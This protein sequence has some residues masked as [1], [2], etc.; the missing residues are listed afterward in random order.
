[1]TDNNS[2]PLPSL[3][4]D[5][6]T[7]KDAPRLIW[8]KVSD[9]VSLLWPDNPKLHDIGA[10]VQ[11]IS[12]HGFQELPKYDHHLGIKAGNGRVEALDW[13]QK[14]GGYDLPRGLASLPDSG[15]WAMPLLIGTD[16]ESHDLA[17]AYAI[18]SNNLTLSGG[19]LTALDLARVWDREGYIALLKGL[20]E[21]QQL[22][23]SVDGDTLDF[24][25][26]V[27]DFN[28]LQ[29]VFDMDTET[30]LK[31]ERLMLTLDMPPEFYEE[32]VS[33]IRSL[34]Q[35]NPQWQAKLH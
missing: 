24:L 20:A 15:E 30:M 1:M 34:L 28:P 11:S 21:R 26:F 4:P 35:E 6:L 5:T 29:D 14:D 8:I 22:P 9:A 23:V 27:T 25:Q 12:R 33:G 32:V 3:S 17:T 7:L 18:D 10:V 16:A 31:D 13:M 19:D 2:S